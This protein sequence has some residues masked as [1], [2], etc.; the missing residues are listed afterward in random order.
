MKQQVV[1]IKGK[2]AARV[3]K[4]YWKKWRYLGYNCTHTELRDIET[5]CLFEKVEEST[6]RFNWFGRKF[7]II[8]DYV[9][10]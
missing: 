4:W 8:I 2:Y 9:K 7:E 10:N 3:K 1:K 5:Y 6:E